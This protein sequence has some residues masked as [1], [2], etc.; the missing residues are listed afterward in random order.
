MKKRV[1]NIGGMRNSKYKNIV[2]LALDV[3][4]TKK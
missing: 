1:T 4:N 3:C 2:K